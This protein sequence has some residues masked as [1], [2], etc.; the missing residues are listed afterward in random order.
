MRNDA[1][2]V[3]REGL[4]SRAGAEILFA[5]S[6]PAGINTGRNLR[7]W[8]FSPDPIRSVYIL[9]RTISREI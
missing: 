1:S 9:S 5:I 7:A 3:A 4:I 6:C 2:T 8:N